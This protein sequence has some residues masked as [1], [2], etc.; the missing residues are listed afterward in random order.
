MI[1]SN[2]ISEVLAEVMDSQNFCASVLVHLPAGSF[3]KF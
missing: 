2:G 3:L 1:K